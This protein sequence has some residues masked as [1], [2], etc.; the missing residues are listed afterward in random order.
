M[1]Y[2]LVFLLIFCLPLPISQASSL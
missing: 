1:R 2:I